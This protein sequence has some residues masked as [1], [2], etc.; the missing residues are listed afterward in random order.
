M[1]STMASQQDSNPEEKP[2]SIVMALHGGKSSLMTTVAEG[3]IPP[4][5]D[6]LQGTAMRPGKPCENGNKIAL[7]KCMHNRTSSKD[8]REE[9]PA[10]RTPTP[11]APSSH[12][13]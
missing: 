8:L 13:L 11:A 2:S 4:Y 6:C 9:S 7:S 5:S 10:E 1:A 3:A 12:R